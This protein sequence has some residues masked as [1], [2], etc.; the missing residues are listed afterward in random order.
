MLKDGTL[1]GK[2]VDR[3]KDWGQ[4]F[5]TDILTGVHNL[6]TL[7]EMVE[8]KKIEPEPKSGQQELYENIINKFV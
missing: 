3:Y 2:I 5:G 4:D 1:E 8:D 6:E 7:A